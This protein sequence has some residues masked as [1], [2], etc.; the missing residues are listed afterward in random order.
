MFGRRKD[1]GAVLDGVNELDAPRYD[2]DPR[3]TVIR[4]DAHI[5]LAN[6]RT[7]ASESV[8]IVRRGFNYDNALDV[9]GDLDMGLLFTSYQRDLKQ[10]E[11]IQK[12]ALGRRALV[13]LHLARRRRV[14]LC[15]ARCP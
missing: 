2:A 1:T 15:F 10:F 8:R 12:R 4:L 5:R 9:N 7:P 11:E 3:G 14:L 6:P 13:R